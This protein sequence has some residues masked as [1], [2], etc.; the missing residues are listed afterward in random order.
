MN[1]AGELVLSRNQ[2]LQTITAADA[3]ASAIAAQRIDLITTEL[4]E[5]IMLTRMQPIGNVFNKFSRI[6]RA[7][8]S[9]K[10]MP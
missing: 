8:S 6:V 9:V 7:S 3:H 2:L 10:S 5:T 1:L 4:Q